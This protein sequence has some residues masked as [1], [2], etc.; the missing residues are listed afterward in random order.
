[1]VYLSTRHYMGKLELNHFEQEL[2][3]S[4]STPLVDIRCGCFRV[5]GL[6]LVWCNDSTKELTQLYIA[7]CSLKPGFC[8]LSL[9]TIIF[10]SL[11][12]WS[13]YFSS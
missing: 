10:Q 13:S 1:V 5:L 3:L 12:L 2:L 6:L 8:K 9:V 4:V 7:V 11:R